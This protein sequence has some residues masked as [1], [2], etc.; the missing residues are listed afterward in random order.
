MK[1]LITI[2]LSLTALLLA[3]CQQDDVPAIPQG[4]IRLRLSADQ[5]LRTRAM[6]DVSDITPWYAVVSNGTSTLYDQQIGRE[7][8]TRL[9]D[10]GTYSI[11]VRNYDNAEAANA[12]DGGWGDAYHEGEAHHVEVSAGGTAYV[13]INCGQALNA[14]FRLD[15]SQFSGIINALTISS[16]KALTFSHAAGTLTREAYFAPQS[17]LTYTI[18]YTIGDD[19][20]TTEPATITLG[21]AATVS[22]LRIKSDIHGNINVAMTYDTEFEDEATSEIDI[23]GT[24]GN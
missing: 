23:D 24:S 6:Q 21:G 8:E 12:A 22:I 11:S 20:K 4:H 7:L 13:H 18:N 2:A 5:A 10:P 16:P 17:T 14:K 1:H 9:F 3:A 19:T 15:Y